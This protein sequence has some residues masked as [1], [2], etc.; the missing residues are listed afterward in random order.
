MELEI[1][2]LYHMTMVLMTS[3]LILTNLQCLMEILK[4]LFGGKM[5]NHIIGVDDELW[6][7]IKDDID[8]PVD[9]EGVAADRKKHIAAKKKLYNLQINNEK[10][11]VSN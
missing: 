7:I 4:C 2:E 1:P 11:L 6:D 10:D 5:Y 3:N 9:E 8:I